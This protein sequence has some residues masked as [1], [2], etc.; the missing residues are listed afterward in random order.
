MCCSRGPTQGAPLGSGS[1]SIVLFRTASPP[2]H[3]ALHSLQGD[4][5]LNKHPAGETRE[6]KKKERK[7]QLEYKITS[8]ESVFSSPLSIYWFLVPCQTW[9][10]RHVTALRLLGVGTGRTALCVPAETGSCPLAPPTGNRA[11][12]PRAPGIVHGAGELGAH[13]SAILTH[14][15]V[16]GATGEEIESESNR[17]KVNKTA[18]INAKPFLPGITVN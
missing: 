8:N 18:T 17:F 11:G 6:R 14:T 10:C 15:A 1:C 3:E 12:A 16:A 7:S 13:Q 9:T 5:S 4:H 2:P